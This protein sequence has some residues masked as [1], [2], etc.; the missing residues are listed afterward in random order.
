MAHA[1][2]NG[3]YIVPTRTLFYSVRPL[4][5]VRAGRELAYE[6]FSQ[7]LLVE[8]QVDH[9]PL[10]GLVRE[11]RGT[12]REP[13]TSIEVPLG[14]LEVANYQ[15]PKCVFDKILYVEKEGLDPIWEGAHLAER[16]DMAIASGKGQPVEAV[17]E[18]F[19]RAEGR[20]Y[21]LFVLHDADAE[22]YGIAHTIA[23]A[24]ERMPNHS[25]E[26]VDLGLTVADA[27]SMGLGIEGRIRERELPEWMPDRLSETEREWFVG[28]RIVSTK[29]KKW[30][31]KRVELNALT[32]PALISYVEAG[33]AEAGADAKIMPPRDVL[34]EEVSEAHLRESSNH[35][36][37]IASEILDIDGLAERV[38]EVTSEIATDPGG[39][40][41][42]AYRE[43]R[44]A[45][46]RTAVLDGIESGLTA[47]N[48][49][50]KSLM[51]ESIRN[52]SS[53]AGDGPTMS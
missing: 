18:L 19:A 21:K 6:Y 53:E 4:V 31:C 2:G 25:V 37:A 50:L 36:L 30:A 51:M 40:I 9:G 7:D 29:K 8:Y 20:D 47:S 39:W 43:D 45:Y 28:E 46:W 42:D 33:L 3:E 11:A 48:D 34:A 24:T 27:V 23:E 15:L 41:T 10:E 52:V 35:L 49:Q 14:T 26:V 13:H 38:V 16:Y 32:A 5:E 17:R 1:S 44:S 12:L 22:G